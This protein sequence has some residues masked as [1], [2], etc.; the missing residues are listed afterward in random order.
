MGIL[1]MIDNGVDS[2]EILPARRQRRF[3]FAV[4]F[5]AIAIASIAFTL[6]FRT[7]PGEKPIFLC[8]MLLRPFGWA[9]DDPPVRIQWWSILIVVP[10]TFA[11]TAFPGRLTAFISSRGIFF[12]W[13]CGVVAA[14]GG[15]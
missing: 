13:G 7:Y 9:L 2:R 3:A 4:T 15:V 6:L 1:A 11:Y 12:W 5:S 10:P 8:R 14:T